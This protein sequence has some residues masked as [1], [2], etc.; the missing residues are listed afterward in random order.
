[1]K[2][3]IMITIKPH[4]STAELEVRSPRAISIRCVRSVVFL[5]HVGCS[6]NEQSRSDG[7]NREPC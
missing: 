6:Y 4:L 2:F 5:V 7:E 1:V 3:V